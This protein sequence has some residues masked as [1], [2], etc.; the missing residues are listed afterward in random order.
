LEEP[1]ESEMVTVLLQS[2]SG[3]DAGEGLKAARSLDENTL[4]AMFSGLRV[5]RERGKVIRAG[6]DDAWSD[7]R[8]TLGKSFQMRI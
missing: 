4:A 7:Y 1:Y 2:T 3:K 6:I 8:I 5:A